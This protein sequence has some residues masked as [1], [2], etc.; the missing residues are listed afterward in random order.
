MDLV[1]SYLGSGVNAELE[2][3][4]LGEIT[5]AVIT[6]SGKI[7]QGFYQSFMNKYEKCLNAPIILVLTTTGG[8]LTWGYMIAR[9]L[10]M[11][12]KKVI[13][14]VPRYC[15]SA[16]TVIALACDKIYLSPVGCLG[17]IDP[18]FAGVN[19]KE[20]HDTLSDS[21]WSSWLGQL[22]SGPWFSAIT[23]YAQRMLGRIRSDHEAMIKTLL[24]KT[25]G[26]CAE[27]IYV[28]FTHAKH[29]GTPIYFEDIPDFGL[30]IAVDRDMFKRPEQRK[31]QAAERVSS[32]FPVGTKKVAQEILSK[33][34]ASTVK[35]MEDSPEE[36]SRCVEMLTQAMENGDLAPHDDPSK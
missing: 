2:T 35:E 17:P 3:E 6:M 10:S 31:V 28:F 12:K 1:S 32:K 27:D 14:R 13:I 26:G 18:Y 15:L 30:R 9:I 7:S 34:P 24:S 25:H 33:M 4:K 36:T 5:Y 11:H 16:G 21:G 29:H 23:S 20:C 8:E 22:W 19:V